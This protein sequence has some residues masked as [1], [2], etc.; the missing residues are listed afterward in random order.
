MA[1]S[2]NEMPRELHN[3]QLAEVDAELAEVIA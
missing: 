1:S 3:R 2:H